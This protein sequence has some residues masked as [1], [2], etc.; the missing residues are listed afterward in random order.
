VKTPNW[1]KNK[2]SKM[3]REHQK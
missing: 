3:L 2:P 1:A